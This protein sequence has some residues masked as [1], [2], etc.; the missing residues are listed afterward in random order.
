MFHKSGSR[1]HNYSSATLEINWSAF[2]SSVNQTQGSPGTLVRTLD[3]T[4]SLK[5]SGRIQNSHHGQPEEHKGRD[6][7][8]FDQHQ[9]FSFWYCFQRR[10][11]P[12][13]LFKGQPLAAFGTKLEQDSTSSGRTERSG[14]AQG[15]KLPLPAVNNPE[16]FSARSSIQQHILSSSRTSTN[17]L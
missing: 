10:G 3:S 8:H 13:W 7:W 12:E 15:V 16:D 4:G 9:N 2:P 1:N 5:D 11:S 6:F 14:W 17:P